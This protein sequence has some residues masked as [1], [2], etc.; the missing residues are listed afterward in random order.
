[1]LVFKGFLLYLPSSVQECKD[2]ISFCCSFF[3]VI[4][5]GREV[6]RYNLIACSEERDQDLM[7]IIVYCVSYDGACCVT[8]YRPPQLR[9]SEENKLLFCC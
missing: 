1:M 9:N 3:I 5:E 8:T 7:F 4:F 2:L 6:Q